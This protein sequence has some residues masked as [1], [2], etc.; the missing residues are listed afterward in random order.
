MNILTSHKILHYVTQLVL[1][2][3]CA[4][5]HN[6]QRLANLPLCAACNGD[7][8]YSEQAE[9]IFDHAAHRARAET[10]TITIDESNQETELFYGRQFHLFN[11]EGA[12]KTLLHLAKFQDRKQ[13]IDYLAAK[14]K[15]FLEH[16]QRTNRFTVIVPLPS[17]SGFLE[18]VLQ[19]A[20][21][22]VNS[23]AG[24]S[25]MLQSVT[26]SNIK[27]AGRYDRYMLLNK[28]L[29]LVPGET[30]PQ[31]EKV[32]LFDDIITT[33]ATMNTAARLLVEEFQLDR[34]QI[35]VFGVF[36]RPLQKIEYV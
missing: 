7:L 18:K 35:G 3:N 11:A 2:E 29:K 26:L 23:E 27:K 10:E 9:H 15:I 21:T 34:S 17:S 30:L 36:Y 25:R 20:T 8:C 1:P 5:C 13:V 32:L 12:G 28:K 33:G 14:L 31:N 6:R 24:I 16:L 22:E 4:H 19:K